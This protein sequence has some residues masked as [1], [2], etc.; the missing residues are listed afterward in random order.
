MTDRA[1]PASGPGETGPLIVVCL[2]PADPATRVHPLTGWID[3]DP[4]ALALPAAEAAAL[5]HGL[6]LAQAWSGRVLAVTAGDQATEETLRQVTALGADALRVPWPPAPSGGAGVHGLHTPSLAFGG[7]VRRPAAGTG[8]HPAVRPA[9]TVSGDV[10]EPYVTELA[11]DERGLA[12]ALAEAIRR[13]AGADRPAL[14]LC[15]D[16]SAERGTGALPAFLAHE[17]GAAQA[18]GLV[19]LEAADGHLVAERRLDGGRRERLRVPLPAVCSVEAAGLRLRRAG[20]PGLLG[21][22]SAAVPLSGSGDASGG[23]SFSPPVSSPVGHSA[24]VE[25]G[26]ARPYRPPTRIV[27]PPAGDVPRDRLLQLTGALVSH[28]PPMVVGPVGAA[29][30]ADALLEFLHRTGYLPQDVSDLSAPTA[31]TGGLQGSP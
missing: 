8:G 1:R 9:H 6:R 21:A 16:R 17:L 28:E 11:A 31:D 15:G 4:D 22:T 14:V 2:R 23:P 26:R 10:D 5:E 18:L 12:G 30:A 7:S 24:G 3:R 19:G 29:E 20:L 27:P 25:V 13:W